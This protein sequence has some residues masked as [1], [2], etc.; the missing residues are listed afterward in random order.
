MDRTAHGRRPPGRRDL[1]VASG[2]AVGSAATTRTP[3]AA[4]SS[5]CRSYRPEELFDDSGALQPELRDCAPSGDAPH[6]RQPARQR[7]AAAAAICACRTSATTPSPSPRRGTPTPRTR[8][9]SAASF[10]TSS[11][12]TRRQRNFRIFGPDETVSNRLDAV[13]EVTARQW[14]AEI[15]PDDQWL[16]PDGRVVEMLSEHQC[17][18][19]L[20]GYLLT[21]RH[22]LFNTYEAF[23]HIV[24]SMFNQ[25]AKWL[26]VTRGLPMAAPDRVAE[27]PAVEPRLAAG[28][29][30]LH[31]PGS[32]VHRSR[33]EQEGGDRPGVPAA[34]CELPAERDGS[35]PA[36]PPLR[37]HRGGREARRAAVAEHG[38][39]GAALRGRHR[40]LG[41]GQQRSRGR[42]RIWS[43]PRR[44]TCRRSRSSRP[45]PSCASTCPLSRSAWSTSSI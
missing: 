19:W 3:R 36:Q 25:H 7:R 31:A 5:G 26:K 4:R 30:R 2:A 37:Q 35:L 23:V 17:Q 22:G 28:S 44:A 21:G 32:R 33:G 42:S 6:G 45:S 40:H 10:A 8:A 43:W 12:P 27:L 15:E 41:L 18:G 24:D 20:E 13:F 34:R 39:R 16:A 1:P 14:L 11:R 9:C 29:Q 38:G